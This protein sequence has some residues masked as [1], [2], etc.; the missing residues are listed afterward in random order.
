MDNRNKTGPLRFLDSSK[1]VYFNIQHSSIFYV[2]DF[3]LAKYLLFI[4]ILKLI[5]RGK[6][7]RF[8]FIKKKAEIASQ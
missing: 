4:Y 8:S 7:V 3:S 2:E 6:C 5:E 1:I